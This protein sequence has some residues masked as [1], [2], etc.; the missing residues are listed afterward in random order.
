MDPHRLPRHSSSHGTLRSSYSQ[1]R[2][3]HVP[4]PGRPL[5]KPLRSVNEN[6]VLLPSPGA[7][8]SM[9]KTTTET[10]DIGIFSIKPVPPS[11]KR[12]DTLS[13]LSQQQQRP[14][15]RPSIEEL[16]RR[17]NGKNLPSYRDTTSEIISMYGSESHKSA[18]S[19]LTPTSSE[20]VGLRSYSITTCGSRHLSHHRSTTTL[21]SQASGGPLQRP[22]SPFPYPTRL[23]RPGVRPASPA[24]TEN[25]RI[26]YSRMVEIDRSSYRT[27]HGPYRPAYPPM[28][29][30]PPPLGFHFA[31]SLSSVSLPPQVPPHS[32]HGPPRPPSMRTHSAASMASWAAPYHERVDSS[33]S[34]ASS[35]TS[36]GNMYHRMPHKVGPS[37]LSAPV[38]RYYDY[39]EGFEPRQPRTLTPV[40]PF[41]PVPT[42]ASNYQR[43]LVLQE[44]DDNL[45]IAYGQ[46]DSAFFGPESQSPY[47]T[48]T[49][50]SMRGANTPRA[51]SCRAIIDRAPSRCRTASIRSETRSIAFDNSEIDR[52]FGRGSDIDLLPSQTGRDS[53]DTFNP[54]LDL[55]SK[56]VPTYRY[57]DYL[58]TATPKTNVNSPQ[59]QVQVQGSGAPTIRSEQGVILRDDTQDEIL[60]EGLDDS[61]D[62]D[63]VKEQAMTTPQGDAIK[64]R[65]CSEPVRGYSNNPVLHETQPDGQHRLATM[66]RSSSHYSRRSAMHGA[67]GITALNSAGGFSYKVGNA[68]APTVDGENSNINCNYTGESDA[69]SASNQAQRQRFQRHKRNQAVP[70]IS[71]SSLPRED[72][73]GFPYI[74][75]SCSTTPIVSP[76]PISPARQLKLKN[77]VPQLMKALPPLPGD[78][79]YIP[80][81]TPSILSTSSNEEDFSEVL[82]PFKFDRSSSPRLLDTGIRKP[83]SI[84]S[85]DR[86]SGLHSQAPRLK[87][88]AKASIDSAATVTSDT[89]MCESDINQHR[90]SRTPHQIPEDQ[91]SEHFPRVRT[92]NRLKLRSSRSSTSSPPPSATV[93]R[94]VATETSD[95]ISDIARHKPRDLFT[96]LPSL[97]STPHASSGRPLE[98]AWIEQPPSCGSLS[99]I[100][101]IGVK[102]GLGKRTASVRLNRPSKPS[103]DSR[104]ME[105][106]TN[107]GTRYPRGLKRRFS[108]LRFLIARTSESA[109]GISDSTTEASRHNRPDQGA[110][111]TNVNFASNRFATGDDHSMQGN[112][113]R[114][115][116]GRRVR[117]KLLKWV[118]DAKAAVRACAKRNHGV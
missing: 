18:T 38:P 36:V 40:Q 35:L 102:S 10:G 68:D 117:S 109:P 37:G 100:N 12:R 111:L 62:A 110:S 84:C 83:E 70:R 98:A 39:T 73:E 86:T 63:V 90:S 11:P 17:N 89:I 75:P 7:L 78:P 14:S 9:L 92:R 74:T 64:R 96:F 2:P 50:E 108:N 118:K 65:S 115:A 41:A 34:R 48:G 19:T 61:V 27:I 22:R 59:R 13:E 66:D 44:S 21:Q 116:F 85:H 87:L 71:T 112:G 58:S 88:K 93:R 51:E 57:T 26:D 30:R 77:S 47:R 43:P 82:S 94:N 8:E 23:K 113:N 3:P 33:S 76:K 67:S 101:P 52:K 20:E 69:V 29:R 104:S 24:L 60:L 54:N 42:H 53:M 32:R 28:L 1:G 80:P 79:D 49:A 91:E 25:G 55:E 45:A 107:P 95:I 103:Y 81:P 114:A 46:R 4:P 16:H 15:S 6:S 106:C 5:H 72:N 97:T 56:D 105:A 99:E 31:A